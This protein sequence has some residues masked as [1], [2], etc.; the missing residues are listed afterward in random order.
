MSSA[1]SHFIARPLLENVFGP[2]TPQLAGVR[3]PELGK[4][5]M[6]Y[7]VTELDLEID[8]EV[9]PLQDAHGALDIRGQVFL[10]DDELQ[11]VDALLVEIPTVTDTRQSRTSPL[12][13][14]RI[15]AP[16]DAN[17]LIIH[18][19]DCTVEVPIPPP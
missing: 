7:G 19:R 12:G 2:G 17:R 11:T 16:E 9:R 13:A 10:P 8:V 14:F 1:K 18:V 3:G 6:L 4:R 15:E 5:Q